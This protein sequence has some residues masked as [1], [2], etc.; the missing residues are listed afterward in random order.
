MKQTLQ[1]NRHQV[2]KG[3]HTNIEGIKKGYQHIFYCKKELETIQKSQKIKE[4]T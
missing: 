1:F 2:Q 3:E 4:F